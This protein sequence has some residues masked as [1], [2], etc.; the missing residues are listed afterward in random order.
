MTGWG[1]QTHRTCNIC[2]IAKA[3][4]T[5]IET[6][7]NSCG[8]CGTWRWTFWERDNTSLSMTLR[9]EAKEL[10][11]AA[12][13][14]GAETDSDTGKVTWTDHLP[15]NL[16]I[17]DGTLPLWATTW[18][19]RHNRHMQKTTHWVQVLNESAGGR[20]C[21]IGSILTKALTV[22]S[23]IRQWAWAGG[24]LSFRLATSRHEVMKLLTLF[25][26]L[27]WQSNHLE[28]SWSSWKKALVVRLQGWLLWALNLAECPRRKF[29][30]A[31]DLRAWLK[32]AGRN[33][34]SWNLKA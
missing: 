30:V 28:S 9:K 6:S 32:L 19:D 29:V 31:L 24:W 11:G 23:R 5:W 27:N 34:D 3:F 25:C 17:C 22:G 13:A 14:A 16:Q 2:S 1:H 33:L 4:L 21:K 18:I 7:W 20:I 15:G 10:Q 8:S 12:G 26:S